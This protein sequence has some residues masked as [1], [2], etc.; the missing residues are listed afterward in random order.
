MVESLLLYT[1]SKC[2][3]LEINTHTY[4]S[5]RGLGVEILVPSLVAL[6]I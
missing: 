6:I 5:P 1:S 3:G 4:I 2:H